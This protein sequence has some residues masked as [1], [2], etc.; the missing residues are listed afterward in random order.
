MKKYFIFII[1]I[2]FTF[3]ITAGITGI[4]VHEPNTFSKWYTHIAYKI[5]WSHS[6]ETGPLVKIRLFNADTSIKYTDIVDET[7][8]DGEFRYTVPSTVPEGN[9]FIRVKTTDND[10]TGNSAPFKIYK[11][12]VTIQES[13][14]PVATEAGKIGKGIRSIMPDLAITVN[15]FIE[16]V[17]QLS[18]FEIKIKNFGITKT[19]KETLDKLEIHYF[20]P[21]GTSPPELII[22]KATLGIPVLNPGEYYTHTINYVFNKAGKYVLQA[23]VNI[24]ELKRFSE[25]TIINNKLQ[26][27]KSFNVTE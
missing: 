22:S 10:Y 11:S 16:P 14:D 27:P 1:A 23:F 24:K 12:V 20:G 17:G 3:N 7:D 8:N 13:P 15:K 2:S 19:P 26:N 6:E 21:D 25:K 4:A 18:K 5:K 9:Y